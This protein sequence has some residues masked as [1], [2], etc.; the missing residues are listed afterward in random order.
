MI[1]LKSLKTEVIKTTF[2]DP[3]YRGILD[4]LKYGNEGVKRGQA[5][6]NLTQMSE[7][8]IRQFIHEINR[9]LV[10]SGHLFLWVDKFHLCQSV[11][12][13]FKGTSS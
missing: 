12:D 3:Q 13:W 7:D 2:F 5:R 1:L 4:R 9:V 8:V 11:L 10:P 6:H